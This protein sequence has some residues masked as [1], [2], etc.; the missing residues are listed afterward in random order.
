MDG[1]GR[2]SYIDNSFSHKGQSAK[3]LQFFSVVWVALLWSLDGK[4]L[5][6]VTTGKDFLIQHLMPADKCCILS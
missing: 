4:T 3:F 2:P 5:T 6:T 1:L